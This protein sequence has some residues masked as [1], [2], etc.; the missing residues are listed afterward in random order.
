MQVDWMTFLV[1]AKGRDVFTAYKYTKPR[2]VERTPILNFHGQQAP[3]FKA[4]CETFR[5]AMFLPPSET[6]SPLPIPPGPTL[7]WPTVISEEIASAIQTSTPNKAPG[8]DGMPFLLLQKTYLT[9]PQLFN[10]LYQ[11]LIEY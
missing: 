10:T 9:A 11:H 2:R 7:E 1:T 4:K 6:P 3:D 5:K 8:P